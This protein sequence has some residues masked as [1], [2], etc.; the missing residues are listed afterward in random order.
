MIKMPDF[1][2][3]Y[4]YE[5]YYHLTLDVS[6]LGKFIA[7]YE[8]FKMARD[9]PGAIVE[10]GVFKGTSFVRFAMFR[11]LLGNYFSSRIIGFDVFSD[12]YPDTEFQE[13]RAQREKWINTAGPSSI[14]PKQLEDVFSHLKIE[15]YE[16]V[17]GDA[18]KTIPRYV[19]EHPELKISIL[20]ID[21]DFVEPTLCVLEYLYDRVMSG[22]VVL[23][24]NYSAFHGDTKGV[25]EFFNGKKVFIKRFP[26]AQRPCYIVKN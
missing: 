12:E 9:I 5:T 16:I 11:E 6:R 26:F 25:D 18:R 21:I 15:N 3:M 17:P 2:K 10:C 1:N 24:D 20:N 7:H 4:E 22:G 19:Q 13:D 8:A 23:L 14:S